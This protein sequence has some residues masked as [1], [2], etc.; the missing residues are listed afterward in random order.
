MDVQPLSDSAARAVQA[1]DV[2]PLG[3]VRKGV[4]MTHSTSDHEGV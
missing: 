1:V 4:V 3:E 2:V